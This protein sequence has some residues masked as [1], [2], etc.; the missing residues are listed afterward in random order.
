M[1]G[2]AHGDP[3]LYLSI[4]NTQACTDF[5]MAGSHQTCHPQVLVVYHR[6]HPYQIRHQGSSTTEWGVEAVRRLCCSFMSV[7]T[8]HKWTDQ[9]ECAYAFRCDCKTLTQELLKMKTNT[10]DLKIGYHT[11]GCVCF[12]E[13]FPECS[14]DHFSPLKCA[15]WSVGREGKVRIIS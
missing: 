7:P 11:A 2:G 3:R 5:D 10:R 8:K 14:W 12:A 15:I 1:W 4:Q 13:S 6:T 9:K